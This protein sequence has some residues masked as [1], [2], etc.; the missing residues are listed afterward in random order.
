M[1]RLNIERSPLALPT[2]RKSENSN[3]SWDREQKSKISV[4]VLEAQSRFR[5]T[6]FLHNIEYQQGRRVKVEEFGSGE[7][8]S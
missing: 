3:I 1:E 2:K 8:H 4:V 5:A 6:F 7:I